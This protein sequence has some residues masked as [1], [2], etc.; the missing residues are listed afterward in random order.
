MWRPSPFQTGGTSILT[1]NE[2]FIVDIL[3]VKSNEPLVTWVKNVSNVLFLD[4]SESG[5]LLSLWIVAKV[6]QTSSSKKFEKLLVS[7]I[8]KEATG[9]HC[10]YCQLLLFSKQAVCI[11]GWVS[12]DILCPD[13]SPLSGTRVPCL[14]ARRTRVLPRDVT[15]AS[16]ILH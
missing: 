10:N 1:R 16:I 2:H 8:R 9:N 5:L 3:F 12:M 6:K 7:S 14:L 13:L 15:P 11:Y 4:E